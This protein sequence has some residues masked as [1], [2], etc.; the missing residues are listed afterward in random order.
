MDAYPRQSAIW[1]TSTSIISPAS[2]FLRDRRA[3]PLESQREWSSKRHRGQ[4]PPVD[5]EAL[6]STFPRMMHAI[7]S[8]A[9]MASTHT[10]TLP[11][12]GMPSPTARSTA[13]SVE[14]GEHRSAS[15]LR[16]PQVTTPASS[17]LPSP[18][19]PDRP[20]SPL[21]RVPP[22]QPG[23]EAEVE[24]GTSDALVIMEDN[25]QQHAANSGHDLSGFAPDPPQLTAMSSSDSL[26]QPNGGAA[27][28]HRLAT[29]QAPVSM[30]Q[31]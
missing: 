8:Q 18:Q 22:S 10:V 4:P 6:A 16:D 7:A 19:S 27:P 9:S 20:T 28:A 21:V 23:D 13:A 3:T 5:V 29:F 15:T 31:R 1:D 25:E 30:V 17:D 24:A 12:P 11:G 2:T 26:L 14:L